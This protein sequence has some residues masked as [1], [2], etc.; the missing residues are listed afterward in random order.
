MVRSRFSAVLLTAFLCML[1]T[2]IARADKIST[3]D[4]FELPSKSKMSQVVAAVG[5]PNAKRAPT[6]NEPYIEWRYDNVTWHVNGKPC[7]IVLFFDKNTERLGAL[8][9]PDGVVNKNR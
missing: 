2:G 1:V 8:R 7:E 3:Q 5:Q 9:G 6:G 4:F